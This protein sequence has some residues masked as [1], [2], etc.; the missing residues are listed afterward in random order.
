MDTRLD[1]EW[2]SAHLGDPDLVVLDCT[3]VTEMD[4]GADEIN[5]ISSHAR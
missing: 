4:D 3:V 2:L 5:N 1:I